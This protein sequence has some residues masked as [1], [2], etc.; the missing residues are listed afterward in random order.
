MKKISKR[1][2]SVLNRN[3]LSKYFTLSSNYDL[4]NFYSL[5][6]ES[7]NRRNAR[8]FNILSKEAIESFIKLD[9][10]FVFQIKIDDKI[11]IMHLIGLNKLRNHAEFIFSA[12]TANGYKIGYEMIWNEILFLKSLGIEEFHLGGGIY[13]N[14]G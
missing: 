5:Y 13:Q 2:R 12:S 8:K 6:L 14:D 9:N 1:K 4:G 11:E 7:L 3:R 10:T